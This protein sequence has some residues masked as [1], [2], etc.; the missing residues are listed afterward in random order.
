M[1]ILLVDPGYVDG[2]NIGVGGDVVF[3]NHGPRNRR[4]ANQALTSCSAIDSPIVIAPSSCE[5]AVFGLMM[6]PVAK[7]P[8]AVGHAPHPCPR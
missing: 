4:S 7:T 5:R 3:G 1:Q 2:A 8:A 6:R